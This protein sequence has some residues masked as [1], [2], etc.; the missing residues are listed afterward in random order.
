M[1]WDW[2]ILLWKL[3]RHFQ[4]IWRGP[5]RTI[6]LQGVAPG[7]QNQIEPQIILIKLQI[8]SATSVGQRRRG[9]KGKRGGLDQGH[10]SCL[11]V[12]GLW[13]VTNQTT[14]NWIIFLLIRKA[15]NPFCG[16]CDFVAEI[17]KMIACGHQIGWIFE[18]F[19]TG[20]G[21]PPYFGNYLA[22]FS[23]SK[24]PPKMHWEE[25]FGSNIARIANAVQCHN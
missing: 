21:P 2:L 3:Q 14:E 22:V 1:L 6:D 17:G 4:G 7:V 8:S 11:Q 12:I 24:I 13:E 16:F 9:A 25:I 19:Q 10:G 18:S 5:G 23:S 20:V 15:V